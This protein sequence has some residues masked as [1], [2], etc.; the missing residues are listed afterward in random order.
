MKID[1]VRAM[2]SQFSY[3]GV[4]INT[5]LLEVV[6]LPSICHIPTSSYPLM[7]KT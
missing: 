7:T 3:T 1:K 6:T 4:M 5:K 2:I